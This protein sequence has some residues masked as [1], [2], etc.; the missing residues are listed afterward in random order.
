LGGVQDTIYEEGTHIFIP[1]FEFPI[2]FDV[3]AKP[4]NI[5]SLTGTKDLQ[6]VNITVRVLSKPRISALP[7]ILKTLGTDYGRARFT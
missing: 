6:M 4:R 2:I 1:W 5:Q 7:V 3:R